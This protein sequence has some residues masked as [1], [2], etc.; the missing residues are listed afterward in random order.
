MLVS[1]YKPYQLLSQFNT[2]PDQ[3]QQRTLAALDLPPFLKPLGRLDYDSEG[4]L[5][6]SD[7]PGAEA[8]FF[9]PTAHIAKTYLVQ[10]EGRMQPDELALLRAGGL[11]I[12]VAKKPHRCQ[13][14]PVTVVQPPDWLPQRDPPVDLASAGRSSW[15]ELTLQEGKN[16]QVRRM[17][18]RLGYPTLRLIRIQIASWTLETL[19]PKEWI[20]LS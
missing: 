11:E 17:T 1:L 20:V 4:L 3:P 6:L 19:R 16:R 12:R 10:I 18:A 8:R 5:L 14:S 13:P 15:L 2:N 9:H 7:E